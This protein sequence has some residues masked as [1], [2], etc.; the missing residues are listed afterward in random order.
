[1]CVIGLAQTCFCF[2]SGIQSTKYLAALDFLGRYRL[3]F[4]SITR[5][6]R[7][8]ALCDCHLRVQILPPHA[9]RQQRS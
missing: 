1:M 3:R 6:E 2:A 5:N 9:L 8:I 4:H 7:E